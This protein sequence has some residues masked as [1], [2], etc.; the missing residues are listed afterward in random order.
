MKTIKVQMR[1]ACA[2]GLALSFPSQ[3]W[4][5]TYFVATT[6]SPALAAM[7]LTIVLVNDMVENTG[8]R[9]GQK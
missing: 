3:I 4:L 1:P 6:F 8:E 9:G 5:G 7:F 2:R